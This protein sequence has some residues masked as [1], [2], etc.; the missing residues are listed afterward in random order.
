MGIHRP[1]SQGP[2]A[3]PPPDETWSLPCHTKSPPRPSQAGVD[4]DRVTEGGDV[5]DG[6]IE[7]VVGERHTA[8]K[9]KC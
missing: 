6:H 4:L 9:G 7:E 5:Q 3:S 1:H 8:V 2:A